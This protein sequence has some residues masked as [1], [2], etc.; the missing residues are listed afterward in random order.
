MACSCPGAD[1]LDTDRVSRELDGRAALVAVDFELLRRGIAARDG[2]G[3]VV[4]CG[5]DG[6]HLLVVLLALP[7]PPA[8]AAEEVE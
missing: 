1:H 4:V 7:P 3:P 6:A 5:D 8:C 2:R